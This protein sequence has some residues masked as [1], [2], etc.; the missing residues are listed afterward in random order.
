[1]TLDLL[2][3]ERRM[4]PGAWFMHVF[5][6]KGTSLAEVLPNDARTLAV[7]GVSAELDGQRLAKL[8]ESGAKSD[9]FWS[10]RTGE[11]KVEMRRR[12]GFITCPWALD[13]L[14]PGA[15]GQLSFPT[16][17]QFLTVAR[18]NDWNPIAN[19]ALYLISLSVSEAN[20]IL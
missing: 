10:F 4:Q 9:W 1:M 14:E 3:V 7:L 16:A 8:L 15:V 2:E 19:P 12:H 20:L 5:L 18:V 11:Y 6:L 17:N 13:E